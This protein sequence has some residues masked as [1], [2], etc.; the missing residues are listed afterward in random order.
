MSCE[1]LGRV[2]VMSCEFLGRVD[3]VGICAQ[4]LLEGAELGV[5]R[6][7]R[8]LKVKRDV[9]GILNLVAAR[10]RQKPCKAKREGELYSRKAIAKNAIPARK[11][12]AR[13]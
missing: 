6:D 7:F 10:I 3:V 13:L 11:L 12:G 8:P 2:D 1:F 5:G 9:H 4:Q